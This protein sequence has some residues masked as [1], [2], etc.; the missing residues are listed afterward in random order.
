MSDENKPLQSKDGT[1]GGAANPPRKMLFIIL[2]V[3][4]LI[5]GVAL[6]MNNVHIPF[7]QSSTDDLI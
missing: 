5:A 4:F 3:V 7:P 6:A 1:I 2:V